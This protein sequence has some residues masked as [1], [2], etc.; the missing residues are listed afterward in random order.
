MIVSLAL[1]K[2][3]R[4]FLCSKSFYN[5]HQI[6]LSGEYFVCQAGLQAVASLTATP[7]AAR[8][9]VEARKL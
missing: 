4:F 7:A 6:F 8:T 5:N 2:Y 9:F 3:I 1:K